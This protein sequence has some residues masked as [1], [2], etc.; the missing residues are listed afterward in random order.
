MMAYP[1]L[2]ESHRPQCILTSFDH[3][4]RLWSN[5]API[6]HTRRKTRRGWLVPHPQLR[7][8]RQFANFRLVQSRFKQR[9]EHTMLSRSLLPRTKI[10]G[11]VG[12]DSVS[13]RVK[14]ALPPRYR[15][16]TVNNSSLQ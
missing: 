12:I 6:L 9:R 7:L 5:R 8:P 3:T 13:N 15:S 1:E 2:P 4:E 16:R 11:V 14:S 10:A